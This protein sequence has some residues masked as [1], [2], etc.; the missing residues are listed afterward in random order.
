MMRSMCPRRPAPPR[1][2]AHIAGSLPRRPSAWPRSFVLFIL[3]ALFAGASARGSPSRP[4]AAAEEG[5]ATG[6]SPLSVTQVMTDLE[7]MRGL[8]FLR[9]VGV[10]RVSVAEAQEY[11]SRDL[12]ETLPPEKAADYQRLLGALGL[13]PPGYDLRGELAAILAEQVAG[14]Y[15]PRT[16]R[17]VLVEGVAL[18]GHAGVGSTDQDRRLVLAHELDHALTDQHFGLE[19]RQRRWRRDGD[20]DRLMALSCLSEGD[21]VLA[22]ILVLFHE[23]GLELRPESLPDAEELIAAMRS[24]R[25][26]GS[27]KL[28]AAPPWVRS[29]LF[30]PYVLGTGLVVDAWKRE[31]W[32]GVNALWRRPPRSTEQLLHPE[33]RDDPPSEIEAR[34]LPPGWNRT[35]VL[36]L[37][38]LGLRIWLEQRLPAAQAGRAAAGWDGDRVELLVRADATTEPDVTVSPG[39][40]GEYSGA[41]PRE[42]GIRAA[43]RLSS[44]WDSYEEGAE[45]LAAADEALR[46]SRGPI[47]EWSIGQQGREVTIQML[48]AP[49]TDEK[50]ESLGKD[51]WSAVEFTGEGGQTQ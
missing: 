50:I 4:V 7:K 47:E 23:D 8:P 20:E 49:L 45:F 33:R 14:F 24:G 30:D 44:V 26:G 27:P 1:F 2:S 32:E 51:P 42:A 21:A 37:G 39:D 3:L 22:M 18:S 17:L 12:D 43:I 46:A 19:A 15:D 34:A 31:G 40:G 36:Q 16:K 28:S 10:E 9:N 41:R 11:L 5:A 6:S 38:E 35:L 29:Q 13:I 48:L 25:L